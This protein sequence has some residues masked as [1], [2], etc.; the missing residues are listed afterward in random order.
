[1]SVASLVFLSYNSAMAYDPRT[2]RYLCFGDARGDFA[3]GSDTPRAYLERCLDR[4]A[5]REPSVKAFVRLDLE[6]AR[7]AADRSDARW[8]AGRPLSAVDGLPVGIKDC[9]DVAGLP[10]EVG[11]RMFKD[12]V[13]P[14]DAAHVAALR[15]GG[16]VVVGKT[17]TTELTMALPAPTMNPWDLTRTP[18]GSSSGSAAAVAAA[19]LPVATGSQVRGSVIRPASICGIVGMKPSYGALNRYGGIDPS[20]SFNHLG[21]LAGTLGDCWEVAH[22]IAVTVGGDPG[23]PP[24]K[25]G[26]LL[27]PAR[28][29]ARLARQCTYGWTQTDEASKAVFAEFLRTLAGCDGAH[30]RILL[31]RDAVGVPLAVAGVA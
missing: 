2:A 25:G 20:P 9:Y 13:A 8:R 7:E 31:R 4:I 26:P 16:A 23:Y 21:I 30:A 5:S 27:P 22:H 12:N 1:M 14:I 19:M 15:R 10:T 29:P 6:R 11:S 3:A 28:R 24:L 17:A 18:G